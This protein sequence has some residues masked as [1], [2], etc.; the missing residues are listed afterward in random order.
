MIGERVLDD[1]NALEDFARFADDT[2]V[3]DR[4]RSIRRINKEALARLVAERLDI[5]LDPDALFDVHIKR[6]HEYKRQLLNILETI[7]LY[8]EMR[9]RPMHNWVPRVKIFAGKAEIGRAH[10]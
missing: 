8:N 9:A 7:A 10:V 2:D 5:H 3:H 6:I 1:T 4:L